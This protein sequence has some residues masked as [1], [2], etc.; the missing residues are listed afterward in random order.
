MGRGTGAHIL[1]QA[2]QENPAAAHPRAPQP[3]HPQAAGQA[4]SWQRSLLPMAP[5]ALPVRD[6]SSC[7][8]ILLYAAS[9]EAVVTHTHICANVGMSLQQE[10]V[11]FGVYMAPTGT[12]PPPRAMAQTR[13]HTLI[14]TY[15]PVHTH[16]D[17]HIHACLDVQMC[18]AAHPHTHSCVHRHSLSP[19][20]TEPSPV[21]CSIPVCALPCSRPQRPPAPHTWPC[22]P[23]K[24]WG[25]LAGCGD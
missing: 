19:A 22:P 10:V 14:L 2:A 1:Y 21:C 23:E 17:L 20:H 18:A 7:P 25:S 6:D 4:G 15:I 9:E 16:M 24:L 12:H 8:S 3:Q 5:A 11:A 13:A